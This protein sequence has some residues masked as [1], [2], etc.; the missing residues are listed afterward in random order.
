MVF[1]DFKLRACASQLLLLLLLLAALLCW[2]HANVD[3][4]YRSPRAQPLANAKQ[5]VVNITNK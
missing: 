5:Q 2:G 1:S 4:M 3:P